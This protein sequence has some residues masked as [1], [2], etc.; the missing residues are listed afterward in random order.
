M[1]N[2]GDEARERENRLKNSRAE[3]VYLEGV[4]R[5]AGE[6][7]KIQKSKLSIDRIVS[8]SPSILREL[9]SA[10]DE[11]QFQRIGHDRDRKYHTNLGEGLGLIPYHLTEAER[12]NG[13]GG[14]CGGGGEGLGGGGGRRKEWSTR[15]AVTEQKKEGKREGKK[16]GKD[17]ARGG[18][19]DGMG[20]VDLEYALEDSQESSSSLCD[21]EQGEKKKDQGGDRARVIGGGAVVNNDSE[22]TAAADPNQSPLRRAMQLAGIKP[23]EG[24]RGHGGPRIDI[25]STSLQLDSQGY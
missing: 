3:V 1:R 8:P 14:R 20:R 10:D 12:R 17:L 5:E 6:I 24:M 15:G 16:G 9:V 4:L 23:W 22:E 19:E 7:F 13:S 2:L 25:F 18:G 21:E 11:D